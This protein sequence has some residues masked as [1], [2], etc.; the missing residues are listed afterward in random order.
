M[1]FKGKRI[2]ITGGTGSLGK[3]IL[4]R[5]QQDDWDCQFVIFNRDETRQSQLKAK[6]PQHEYFLGDVSKYTDVYRAMRRKVDIVFHLAA[7]KQVPSAQNNVPATIEANII[8]SLNVVDAALE[9]GV[10]QVVASSTDKACAPCNFYGISKASMEAI[11]Q[12]ANRFNETTFHLARYGNV[13]CSNASVIPLFERQAKEGGPLTVTHLDMTRFWIT[14]D[15]AID[16]LLV[17][18]LQQPGVIV[19]PKAGAMSII[20]VAKAVGPGLD[21][22]E[23]GIRAGEKIH[24]A[25]VSEAESFFA[26]EDQKHF[27]IY[28][29]GQKSVINVVP[30]TYTSDTAPHLS[31]KEMQD[32]I[33]D[34]H[35]KFE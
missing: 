30:F 7:Y 23:I 1:S 2:L 29:Y 4:Q 15:Q 10:K 16:L 12:H 5:A 17:A 33:A 22:K 34:Y 9:A 26:K 31:I 24:E 32:M 20:E 25:L 21:I 3:A 18:L 19:I 35:R 27:Y 28:P 8:G 6:Y 14:L 11:F 13:V